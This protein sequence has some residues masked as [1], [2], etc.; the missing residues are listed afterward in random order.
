MVLSSDDEIK[1]L[2]KIKKLIL[3]SSLI[4]R[5][6]VKNVIMKNEN[7]FANMKFLIFL[8]EKRRNQFLS[9]SFE[10]LHLY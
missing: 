6:H 8:F 3:K 7:S 10:N 1:I 9:E 5:K 2:T 4:G